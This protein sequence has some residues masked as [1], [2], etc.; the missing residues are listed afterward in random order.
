MFSLLCV[1]PPHWGREGEAGGEGG[2]V[3]GRVAGNS[4]THVP[5]CSS[6][7]RARGGG[8]ADDKLPSAGTLRLTATVMRAEVE[9]LQ[10]SVMTSVRDTCWPRTRCETSLFRQRP[11]TNWRQP[12]G[13]FKSP[14]KIQLRGKVNVA[15][16]I[17][18][19]WENLQFTPLIR[20]K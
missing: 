15:Q 17:H 6:G 3:G 11:G 2:C 5:A 4:C 10:L 12:A 18:A 13:W 20:I 9:F 8:G 16:S 1:K 14:T 19:K 7:D